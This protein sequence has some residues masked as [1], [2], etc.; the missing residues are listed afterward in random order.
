MKIQLWSAVATASLCAGFVIPSQETLKELV[1]DDTEPSYSDL[2][3]PD[4][5]TAPYIHHLD[6][7]LDSFT[8]CDDDDLFFYDP[9][10]DDDEDYYPELDDDDDY[11]YYPEDLPPLHPP[12]HP[13]SDKTIY[14]L[15][16]ES[17]Y[18]TV[19]AK[20]VNED[21]DLV[22]LLNSTKS[23]H[24]FFAPTDA[25][26]EKIPHHPHQKP[27]AEIIRAVAKYHLV[28][29]LW[30]ATHVFHSHTLPTELEDP[31]LNSLPQRLA[32][33]VG[34]KGLTVNFYSRIVATDIKGSNGI[35]HGID[36]IL[37]PPPSTLAILNIIPTLFSTTVLALQ[38]TNLTELLT[39]NNHGGTLF[40]PSN[41]AFEK[42]GFKLNAFLFS[43]YGTKYLR[44]L[45]KYHI[46]PDRTLYSDIFY[47]EKGEG[48]PFGVKGYTH[49]DLPTL[50]PGKEVAVDVVTLGP[51]ASLKVNGFRDVAVSDLLAKDGS[52]QVLDRVLIP[53]KE[54]TEE[55][56]VEEFMTVEEL[57]SRLEDYLDGEKEEFEWPHETEL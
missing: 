25:A 53:P 30:D 41:K 15:I 10:D 5:E 22:N 49:L 20:I 14:E 50:L 34:W 54:E 24:T 19:L 45:L 56:W 40:A 36:S 21:D 27:P 11:Y 55:D 23:N 57:K 17:K 39:S 35:I 12:H 51:Y 8:D 9:V 18:T 52:V 4:Y 2:Q 31:A 46:V 32:I 42:L 7:V 44:A 28:P 48:R 47:T 33:R 1:T 6:A 43:P 13:P 37:V 16:S 29:G 26:F 3:T 38:K